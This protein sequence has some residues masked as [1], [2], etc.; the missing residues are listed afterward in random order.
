MVNYVKLRYTLDPTTSFPGREIANL[1][2]G[3][4]QEYLDIIDPY[5][6]VI[7][8]ETKNKLGEETH[9]HI[10]L[11]FTTDKAT[12]TIRKAL[13]RKWKNEGDERT[14]AALYSLKHEEDVKDEDFFF[15]YPLKQ[16]GENLFHKYNVYPIGFDVEL[17][18]KLANEF[19][20]TSVTVNRNKMEKELSKTSTYD[21]LQEYLD[22]L[23]L[24]TTHEVM[25]KTYDF[26]LENKMAMNVNT[27]HGYCVTYCCA[28]GLIDKCVILEK[29][30][31]LGIL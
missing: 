21:K 6:V 28:T 26:Y 9:P 1:V 20:N 17:Q 13:T 14:R 19:Y 5:V 31:S 4:I 11:H 29:I 30:K 18:I 27:I 24:K 3:T 12:D 25:S 8:Y 10:H 23:E 2:K 7:G 16:G 22:P 15:R